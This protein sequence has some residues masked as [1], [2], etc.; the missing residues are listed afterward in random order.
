MENIL[1]GYEV[2]SCGQEKH[3]SKPLTKNTKQ[4]QAKHV[5]F[6]E[7]RTSGS[8]HAGAIGPQTCNEKLDKCR[9]ARPTC[10]LAQ[11]PTY[12][13]HK[14]SYPVPPKAAFGNLKQLL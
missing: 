12:Q 5:C 11:R 6:Q 14:M 7:A 8:S 9:I 13:S 10:P 1:H 3:E 4:Y 2:M